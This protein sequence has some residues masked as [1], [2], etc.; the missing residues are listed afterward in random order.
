[1]RVKAIGIIKDTSGKTVGVKFRDLN[2]GLS[3][4]INNSTILKNKSNIHCNNAI[5]DKN[6]F[7]R[8][9]LQTK[10]NIFIFND[11]EDYFI[12]PNNIES[13]IPYINLYNKSIDNRL[14]NLR[15][16][17]LIESR[18]YNN[19]AE[20]LI[21]FN[22]NTLDYA[23]EYGSH[24]HVGLGVGKLLKLIRESSENSVI[25]IHNHPTKNFI[26]STDLNNMIIFKSI[27]RIEA[28]VNTGDIWAVSKNNK[29]S[30][31]E[32][33]YLRNYVDNYDYNNGINELYLI[34]RGKLIGLDYTFTCK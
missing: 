13:L 16:K 26:S 17:C 22:M 10:L 3:I 2:T 5:I 24:K 6:G 12:I 34:L 33:V 30:K 25:I 20:V 27:C 18:D 31:N 19:N 4:Y 1:M 29:Y 21:A 23:I 15:I 32:L 7:I 9:K 28:I 14:H 8:S 11:V